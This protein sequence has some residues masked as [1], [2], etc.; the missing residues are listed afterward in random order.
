MEA[1]KPQTEDKN[2]SY[3][4]M[5]LTSSMKLKRKRP[6]KLKLNEIFETKKTTLLAPVCKTQAKEIKK[7]EVRADKNTL[8]QFW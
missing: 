2:L 4:A 8:N 6:K 5:P 1:T 3:L 7:Y